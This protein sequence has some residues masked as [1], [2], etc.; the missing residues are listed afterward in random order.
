MAG[1]GIALSVDAKTIKDAK[2]DV[3]ALNR[4]LRDTEEYK[5]LEVGK[6]GLPETQRTLKHLA[7]ELRRLKVLAREGER[8]GGVLNVAQFR[9]AGKLSREIA[10]NFEKYREQIRGAH[11]E[12][13]C[14]VDAQAKL[15]DLAADPG[16]GAR[17][18]AGYLGQA[19]AFG[20]RIDAAR[21]HRDEL[22]KHRDSFGAVAEEA[23]DASGQIGG[24]GRFGAGDLRRQIR[25]ALGW[26]LGIAGVTSVAGFLHSSLTEAGEYADLYGAAR[27]RGVGPGAGGYGYSR[28]QTVAIADSLNQATAL[29]GPSLD[30]LTQAVQRFSRAAGV[31]AEVVA[32][33]TGGIYRLTGRSGQLGGVYN[34]LSQ[35][36]EKGRTGEF[37][38]TNLGLMESLAASLGG[39]LSPE[40]AQ[41][42]LALQAA[43]WALP[44]QL[45]K[46]TSGAAIIAGVNDAIVGGGGSRGQQLALFHA[47]GGAGVKSLSGLVAVQ[48]RMESGAFGVG[49]DGRSNLQALMEFAGD[50]WGREGG[51]LSLFAQM[52][53]R[54][55]MGG[56]K[57]NQAD[58][59]FAAIGRGASA[60]EMKTAFA[61]RGVDRDAEAFL[62]TPEGHHARVQADLA[63]RLLRVGELLLPAVDK[64]KDALGGAG[65]L[66]GKGE[67]WAGLKR[68]F[69]D[70]PLGQMAVGLLA[71]DRLALPAVSNLTMGGAGFLAGA[72][73]HGAA[74]AAGG[75]L[76]R[77]TA[78]HAAGKGV[79]VPGLGTYIAAAGGAYLIAEGAASHLTQLP[80]P[81][82]D[83]ATANRVMGVFG[84]DHADG[85]APGAVLESILRTL[86]DIRD[87]KG[88]RTYGPEVFG[89]PQP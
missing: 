75:V 8:H 42:A 46:G 85:R 17:A 43:L 22:L 19:A 88:V 45:G 52:N 1:L 77:S 3:D 16:I 39:A 36:G 60:E 50:H 41:G 13:W 48:R 10:A 15:Q 28:R 68:A 62:A 69:S 7:D 86:E 83:R 54:Q 66:F 31:S 38:Q 82:S 56:L 47:F 65:D 84:G 70:N 78:S 76:A 30:R 89:T 23:V 63:D 20:P 27:M 57:W 32:G 21:Q 29:V 73:A 79:F 24:F 34:F 33:Y 2:R 4:S 35:I 5:S 72:A 67:L 18:R 55:L 9:E 80:I 61:G 26:G 12:F 14:L 49:P 37:L 25:R 81:D 51:K 87:G 74:D 44:G 53:L 59:L 6:E 58:A 40:Q 71:V 64:F 11:R